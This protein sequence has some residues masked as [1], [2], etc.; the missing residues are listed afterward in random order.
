MIVKRLCFFSL[1]L[2]IL[3]SAC[4]KADIRTWEIPNPLGR[5]YQQATVFSD[6]L[7]PPLQEALKG[8]QFEGMHCYR[9]AQVDSLLQNEHDRTQSTLESTQALIALDTGHGLTL[10]CLGFGE[11]ESWF[12]EPLG[13]HLLLPGRDF[14]ITVAD[15]SS[16]DTSYRRAWIFGS[17]FF[18]QYSRPDGGMEGYGFSLPTYGL[19]AVT[20]YATTDAAGNGMVIQHGLQT[21]TFPNIGLGISSLP[22]AD[23]N[24]SW[25]HYPAPIPFWA[26]YMDSIADFPTTEED[27]LRAAAQMEARA[28][29]FAGTDYMIISPIVNLR[30]KAS[31]SSKKLGTAAGAI[32]ARLLGQKAGSS[33]PWYQLQIGQESCWVSGNY[34]WPAQSPEFS[35][36]LWN[37]PLPMARA[38]SP[39]TLRAKPANSAAAVMEL[40]EGTLMHVM[41]HMADGW[42]H[43]S[44][45][46]GEI[47]WEMDLEGTTGFLPASAVTERSSLNQLKSE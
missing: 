33:A 30:E 25:T 29:V 15:G 8:S 38:K 47:G 27:I 35:F 18:V 46:R 16:A 3:S 36:F 39:V 28:A 9:G 43:V 34:A 40:P 21:A 20:A 22:A 19:A 44:V 37:H 12:I 1:L 17:R 31:S 7:P 6:E 5:A 23:G 42:L 14:I 26:E 10:V 4:A 24:S 2:L 45:P 13:S 11:D 41:A 32:P